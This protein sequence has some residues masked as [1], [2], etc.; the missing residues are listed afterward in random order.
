MQAK[1]GITTNITNVYQPQTLMCIV[2]L[3]YIYNG[4]RDNA[5]KSKT[6]IYAKKLSQLRQLYVLQDNINHSMSGKNAVMQHSAK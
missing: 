1:T 2:Q 3:P 6:A 5:K 4:N